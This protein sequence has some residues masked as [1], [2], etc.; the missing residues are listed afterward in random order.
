MVAPIF[1]PWGSRLQG[2]MEML[3]SCSY[4]GKIHDSK[5]ICRKKSETLKNR[6]RKKTDD[7]NKF[8]WSGAWKKKAIEIKERDK[9]LCQ[10]CIRQSEIKY[11]PHNLEVHHIVGL[12]ND[13]NKRLDNDNLITLC[14][15][16]HEMAEAGKIDASWLLL[17]AKE[18]EESNR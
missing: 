7:E 6:Q 15:E 17:A 5:M 18:Q 4:C 13:Y 12:R 3:R 11:N 10:V 9:Y 16:H 14:R 1:A 2:E 8:R